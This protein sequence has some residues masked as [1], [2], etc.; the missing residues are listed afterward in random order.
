MPVLEENKFE[1]SFKNNKRFFFLTCKPKTGIIA[2]LG[3][4]NKHLT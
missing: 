4:M 3:K 1:L 2:H